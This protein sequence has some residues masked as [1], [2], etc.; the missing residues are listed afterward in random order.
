MLAENLTQWDPGWPPDGEQIVFGR[1]PIENSTLQL[2]NLDSKQVS[3]IPG[4]Q[5]L[6]SPGWSPDG[7]YLA[8]LSANWSRIVIFAFKRQTWYDWV[9]EAAWHGYPAWSCD[10]KCLYSEVR[11]TVTPGCNRVQLGSTRPGLEVDL[12]HLHQFVAPRPLGWSG[13]AP[14]GSPFSFAT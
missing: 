5:G 3:I 6:Y 8:A 11:A 12:K 13:I 4:S 1:N 10:G 9:S 7:R 2:L 14:D